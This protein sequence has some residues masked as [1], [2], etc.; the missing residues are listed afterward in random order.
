ML[1]KFKDVLWSHCARPAL[2]EGEETILEGTAVLT[3]SLVGVRCG[4]LILTNRRLMWY[5]PGVARP[6][7]PISGHVNLSDIASVDKGTLLDFIAGGRRLRLR[8]R[9]G[10]D[11]CLIEGQSRLDEWIATLRN[12]IDNTQGPEAS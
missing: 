9:S 1:S 8:L 2:E 5:E 7:K 3:G 4:P 12:V 11:K 6:L 10:K